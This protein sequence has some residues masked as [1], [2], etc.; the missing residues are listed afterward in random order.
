VTV[1]R[2]TARIKRLEASDGARARDEVRHLSEA[3]LGQRICR[4]A[5]KVTT[6]W[7]NRGMSVAAIAAETGWSADDPRFAPL[8]AEAQAPSFDAA[9][10]LAA[11]GHPRN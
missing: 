5:E 2:L 11:F 10:F 4:L 9:R 6:G 7:R 3:E 1:A 8:F